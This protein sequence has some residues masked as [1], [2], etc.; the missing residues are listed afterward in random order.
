MTGSNTERMR[1]L[2]RLLLWLNVQTRRISGRQLT[3][4]LAIVVGLVSGGV[5][6]IFEWLLGLIKGGL[7]S[8]FPKENVGWL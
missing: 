4:V 2:E 6:C 3:F 1:P 8:W 5:T 7:T